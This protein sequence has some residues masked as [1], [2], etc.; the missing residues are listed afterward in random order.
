[1][2]TSRELQPR[3][4]CKIDG[5][6]IMVINHDCDIYKV[7]HIVVYHIY[8]TGYE[9]YDRNGYVYFRYIAHITEHG[10]ELAQLPMPK[11]IEFDLWQEE[12]T[13]LEY[14]IDPTLGEVN[15]YINETYRLGSEKG[16]A[17]PMLRNKRL[18]I[19]YTYLNQHNEV[20][21]IYQDYR[22]IH[23]GYV[24]CETISEETFHDLVSDASHQRFQ[25][26]DEAI[27]YL[28]VR[29]FTPH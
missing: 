7:Y 13:S 20:R 2:L 26:M 1:M 19:Q 8:A 25:D 18:L 22:Y 28:S 11:T 10:D 14:R 12:S 3:I 29:F 9:D 5:R 15:K 4:G 27:R 24:H 6:N 16:Y 23:G 17:S 21:N